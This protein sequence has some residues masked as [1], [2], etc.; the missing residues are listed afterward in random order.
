MLHFIASFFCET[1]V[2]LTIAGTA[3]GVVL[4]LLTPLLRRFFPAQWVFRLLIAALLFFA[5]PFYLLLPKMEPLIEPVYVSPTEIAFLIDIDLNT[6]PQGMTP[7][8][9]E[10]L[11]SFATSYWTGIYVVTGVWAVVML[12]LALI[13]LVRGMRFTS[14]L[15]H[16][17]V[18]ITEEATLRI[19]ETAVEELGLRKK[20]ALMRCPRIGTPMLT[21]LLYPILYLPGLEMSSEQTRLVLLHELTHYRKGDLWVKC[22]MQVIGCIH[23]MNP[24]CFFL[25][26]QL[27]SQ[28][29]LTCDEALSVRM[30]AEER[31]A[32]GMAVLDLMGQALSPGCT[33]F[34][35]RGNR[36]KKRL[37]ALMAPKE[38]SKILR[39]SCGTLSVLLTASGLC[40][41]SALGTSDAFTSTEAASV[42]I[43]GGADGPTAVFVTTP[44][45]D[46]APT[47]D[48]SASATAPNEADDAAVPA[49]P[50]G[51]SLIAPI[52]NGRAPSVG[53]NGYQGHTGID[54]SAPVGASIGAA[55]DGIVVLREELDTGYGNY[56]VVD[57]GG[58]VT[59]LYAQCDTMLVPLGDKVTAGQTIATSGKS[60]A[61]TGPHCHFEL[62]I[63]GIAV[64][65]APYMQ[66]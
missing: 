35:K 59:T 32:Y 2:R 64:D 31:H 37:S 61:T 62:R 36:F 51:L 46:S 15:K 54:Y 8:Q 6:L 9:A 12:L 28:C 1:V 14:A 33:T 41:S 29:E 40:L 38:N 50:D 43:I 63:D 27:D 47:S 10:Q 20:P 16:T 25:R 55:A 19:Y 58:G 48:A 3:A 56:L 66:P 44:K 30:N 52:Q 5:A 26:R 53:F 22:A 4:L 65:A 21:G 57:H 11:S 60:G 18:P 34:S 45:T 42:G 23:W 39:I 17:A 7:E 49:V 13:Q 24:V